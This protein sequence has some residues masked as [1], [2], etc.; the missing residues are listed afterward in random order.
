MVG[1]FPFSAGLL[2]LMVA[3][4]QPDITCT[5]F[6]LSPVE[7]I[8][9]ETIRKSGLADRAKT[10]SGNFF[11]DAFPHGDLV[12]MGNILHDWDEE[13]K[14]LLMKKPMKRCLYSY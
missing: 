13:K 7:P 3:R 8:A 14:L 9:K 10:K 5:T 6:D 2:S 4:H 12:A 1:Y 11:A